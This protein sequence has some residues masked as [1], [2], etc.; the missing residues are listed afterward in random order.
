MLVGRPAFIALCAFARRTPCPRAAES[1]DAGDAAEL[2]S[3][4]KCVLIDI[5]QPA[6]YRLDGRIDGSVNIAAYSW[7]HGFHVPLEDFAAT[8]GDDYDKDAQL[9]LIHSL[10]PLATG[11]AAVLEAAGFSNCQWVDG[12]LNSWDVDELI[13][14]DDEGLVGSWV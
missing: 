10:P 7:E 9:I 5:R 3:A 12:G 11:A 8:I 4:G 14:D 13:V 2:L 6:E 1:I